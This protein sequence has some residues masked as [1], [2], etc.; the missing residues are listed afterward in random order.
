MSEKRL[1]SS[2][3]QYDYVILFLPKRGLWKFT[4]P[5]NL[6]LLSSELLNENWSSAFRSESVLITARDNKKVAV[7]YFAKVFKG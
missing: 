4:A 3:P 6:P 5:E 1:S 7:C 2:K